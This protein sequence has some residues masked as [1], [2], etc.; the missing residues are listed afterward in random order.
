MALELGDLDVL[1]AALQR[2]LVVVER[3]A[4]LDEALEHT[5]PALPVVQAWKQRGENVAGALVREGDVQSFG[6]LEPVLEGLLHHVRAQVVEGDL[7]QVDRL[8][9][10]AALLEHRADPTVQH[11]PPV[12][13]NAFVEGAPV[14]LARQTDQHLAPGHVADDQT[15]FGQRRQ[16]RGRRAVVHESQQQVGFD[17]GADHGERLEHA[18]LGPLQA[19]DPPE[20]EVFDASGER[21]QQ[22][23]EVLDRAAR[24]G[25]QLADHVV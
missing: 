9:D 5:R 15:V 18:P 6:G 7:L 1:S 10:P 12:A 4:E 8:A 3:G 21:A 24:R 11:L 14:R 16:R 13:G 23:L 2:G 20:E 22:L 17:R 25:H 19:F